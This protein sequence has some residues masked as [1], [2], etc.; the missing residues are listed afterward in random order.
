V[1]E[2]LTGA[3]PPTAQ[4]LFVGLTKAQEAVVHEFQEYHH[5]LQ[6]RWNLYSSYDRLLCSGPHVYKWLPI[7]VELAAELLSQL[8]VCPKGIDCCLPCLC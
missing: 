8:P 1:A 5:T 4:D 7:S 2:Y 6:A 3:L